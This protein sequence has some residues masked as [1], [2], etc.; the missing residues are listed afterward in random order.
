MGREE[1]EHGAE[2]WNTYT[3]ALA[4]AQNGK[5]ADAITAAEESMKLAQEA[6][7]DAY[8]KMNKERIEEWSMKK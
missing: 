7:Y 5:Y 2:V 6:K 8:V 3:L 4:Q 1:R